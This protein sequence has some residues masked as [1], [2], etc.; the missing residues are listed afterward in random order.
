MKRLI[1]PV[2][3]LFYL[4]ISSLAEEVSLSP[5]SSDHMVI[6]RDEPVAVWWQA[7][8]GM[9]VGVKFSG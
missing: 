5:L 1:L 4:L 3:A 6:Q 9:T 8:A 7:K 2:I